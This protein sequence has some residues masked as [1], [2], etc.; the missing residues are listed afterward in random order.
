LPGQRLSQVHTGYL[1]KKM[2]VKL[3]DRDRH[4]VSPEGKRLLRS[5]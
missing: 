2:R 5:V 4:G 1:A 3:P